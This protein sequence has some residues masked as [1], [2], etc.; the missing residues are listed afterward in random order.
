[1]HP[2]VAT[3]IANEIVNDRRQAARH[4]HTAKRPAR[5]HSLRRAVLGR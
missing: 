5:R 1:V 4:A 2:Y 3:M